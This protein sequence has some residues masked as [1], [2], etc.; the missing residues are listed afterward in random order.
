LCEA[1]LCFAALVVD[2]QQPTVLK[3]RDRR[4]VVER[5]ALV[6]AEVEGALARVS[7]EMRPGSA[8]RVV[9]IRQHAE[10]LLKM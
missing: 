7:V 10:I 8:V 2:A 6:D 9:A 4:V 3:I 5:A 1:L